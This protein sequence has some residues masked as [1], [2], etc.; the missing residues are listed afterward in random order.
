MNE[1]VNT[2]LLVGD[3]FM[4][5]IHLKQPG[6]TYSA[7][8]PFTKKKQRIEKFM[9]TGNTIFIYKNKLDKAC[10]QHDVA[11]GKS[12]DL[13]K[14]TQLVKVLSDK[15]FKI[16]Y[17]PIYDGYQRGLASMVYKFLI[18]NLVEVVLLMNQ[19]INW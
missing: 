13:V 7:C 16:E 6:F 9:Q 3:K 2:L 14:R 15:A 12:G 10:F 18:K 4:P 17:D 1:I 5:E 8:G 19:I 11:Y